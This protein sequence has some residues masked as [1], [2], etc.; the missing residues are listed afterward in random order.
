MEQNEFT[1]SQI[2]NGLKCG[3][4]FWLADWCAIHHKFT[5]PWHV[6]EIMSS[7]RPL[8]NFEIACSD[9]CSLLTWRIAMKKFQISFDGCKMR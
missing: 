4:G 5:S 3:D 7:H 1:S 2:H 8:F 6:D 9:S